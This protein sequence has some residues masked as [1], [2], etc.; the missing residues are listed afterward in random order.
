LAAHRDEDTQ[1]NSPP[2]TPGTTQTFSTRTGDVTAFAVHP[3]APIIASGSQNQKIHVQ[4]FDGLELNQIRYHE[5]FL[6]QRIGPVSCLAFHPYE[7]STKRIITVL[8]ACAKQQTCSRWSLT[9][10]G[11]DP[12][13][14]QIQDVPGGWRY[15]LHPVDLHTR[16]QQ[17]LLRVSILAVC[18]VLL[19]ANQ[20][21]RRRWFWRE[22]V[23]KGDTSRDAAKMRLCYFLLRSIV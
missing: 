7:P 13:L 6:G 9:K 1:P 12:H 8:L 10:G 20:N 5:G 4:D 14:Q 17:D 11:G 19:P 18:P 3:Y 2:H 23:C 15:R 21:K 16:P 22:N